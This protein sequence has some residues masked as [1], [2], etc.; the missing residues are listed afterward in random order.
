MP[1]SRSAARGARADRRDPRAGQRPASRRRDSARRAAIRR[2]AREADEVVAR[3]SGGRLPRQR[4]RSGS[5]A[6]PPPR[7][8]ARAGAPR[9]RGL[10]PRARD[11]HRLRTAGARSSQSSARQRCD[12]ADD[13][14]RGRPTRPRPRAPR[15]RPASRSR[16]A[17]RAASRARRPRRAL[18]LAR[19]DQSLAR[20]AGS[21]ARPCRTRA[22]PGNAASAAQSSA[23]SALSGS[24]WPVTKA[25]ARG[26]VAVG[27]RHAGVGGRGDARGHARHDLE[28][29]ARRAQRLRL[30]AAASEHERVAA[31]EPDDG[32]PARPS[33][34]SS[35][36][37][38][39]STAGARAL[40]T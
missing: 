3:G 29:D 28:A 16:C 21:G 36:M 34:S 32:S 15:C 17:G 24:S 19:R 38:S 23:D 27:D 14:D 5:R 13:R 26:G 40:P 33:T 10:R 22:C 12:R 4:A 25:T 35:L 9:A 20:S 8:R 37:S 39:C 2:W 18:G 6:P 1:R 11:R 7:R 31:L 30:L